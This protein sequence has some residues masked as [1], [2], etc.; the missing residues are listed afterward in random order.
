[1]ANFEAWV[2][3]RSGDRVNLSRESLETSYLSQDDV[4]VRVEWTTLNYKDALAVTGR[5]PILRREEI[6]PGIDFAGTVERSSSESFAPG[7]LVVLNGWGVGEGHNGG[8]AGQA[9]VPAEWLTPLP[10]R[11]STRD[12]MAVGTAGYTAA[13]CVDRLEGLG[14]EPEAGPILVTG[15]TGGVGSVA[16]LLLA[17]RGYEVVA[18]TGRPDEYAEKLKTLGAVTII[19]RAELAGPPK[20]LLKERWAGVV[21]AVGGDVLAHAIGSTLANGV[22]ASTGMAGGGALNTSVMPFILRGVTLA[23][24]NSV[25]APARMRAKAWARLARDLELAALRA[26]VEEVSFDELPE[27]ANTLLDA[28]HFGRT[29]AAVP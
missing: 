9:C 24:V 8:W 19:D 21:D 4:T 1:M 15:A 23:G 2:A 18:V 16:I 13:L 17:A 20:P 27:R 14:L 5:A 10:G 22:V 29:I 25:T 6:V 12:A 3:R 28:Q 7:D 11:F 26:I